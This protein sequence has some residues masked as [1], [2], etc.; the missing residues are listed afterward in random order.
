MD[1]VPPGVCGIGAVTA[2]GWGRAALWNGLVSG[3]EAGG[4]V[5]GHGPAGRPGWVCL[6]PDGGDPTD[7]P[8]RFARALRAAVRE[9]VDDGRR[10]GWRPGR[11]GLVHAVVLG[12]VDLWQ[13]FYQRHGGRLAV[14]DYLALMPS[15]PLSSV[16]QEFGFHG[17]VVNVSA[18]CA[19]GNVALL[20]AAAWIDAGVVDDVVV[21]ATDLSCTPENTR[22]FVAL[23]VGVTDVPPL[24]ACRPFQPGSRGFPM[25]E[26]A[27]AMVLSR[28]AGRRYA[29]LLGG[30]MTHDGYHA[31][32]IDPA[33]PQVL[34]C[35]AE[36]LAQAGVDGAD[37]GY[38]NAHGPG[39]AQ[40]D[41]AEAAVLDR[42]LG[43]D[44]WLYALKPLVG[45]CQGAAAAVEVAAAALAYEHGVV[46]AAP[47]RTRG[48]HP[49][50]LDGAGPLLPRI[51]VKT[52]LGLGG[53]NSAV[54]LGPPD[55]GPTG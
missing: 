5:D 24:E 36:A 18:M 27:V 29:R 3:T 53:H 44:T 34:R 52:S 49:R 4:W 33:L 42:L 20:T 48:A 32:S 41:R 13:D 2:Y 28:G 51:T 12:E 10:R 14:H 17:P 23:G 22:H 25:G 6:V 21:L 26:A 16:M 35:V 55:T 31:T 43:P 54:V 50:L 37:V 39:T 11:V 19:S 15:T 7:G 8:S 30:A 47:V 46:P 38:L 9:A 45:H 1:H 40:C